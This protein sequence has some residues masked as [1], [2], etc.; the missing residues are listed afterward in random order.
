MVFQGWPNLSGFGPLALILLRYS[1]A[2]AGVFGAICGLGLILVYLNNIQSFGFGILKAEMRAEIGNAKATI[3]QVRALAG[4][5]SQ[6]VLGRFRPQGAL[7]AFRGESVSSYEQMSSS[8][9]V[10]SA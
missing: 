4:D 2:T 8:L 3:E 1:A 5:L 7:G 10:N 6:I 9:L